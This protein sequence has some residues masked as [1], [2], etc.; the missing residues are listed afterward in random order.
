VL[1][2]AFYGEDEGDVT[3]TLTLDDYGTQKEITAP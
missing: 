1:K 2:G 3:Y